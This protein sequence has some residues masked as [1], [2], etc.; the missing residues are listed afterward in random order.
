MYST[1]APGFR[2][3]THQAGWIAQHYQNPSAPRTST[4]FVSIS[5][6]TELHPPRLHSAVFFLQGSSAQTNKLQAAQFQCLYCSSWKPQIR[7]K[8]QD[9]QHNLR[10]GFTLLQVFRHVQTDEL[11]IDC[12][13]LILRLKQVRLDHLKPQ[14]CWE[15]QPE[16][17]RSL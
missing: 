7:T 16:A 3:L 14:R 8:E 4:G 13:G 15:P 11:V 6:C 10:L 17:D 2:P 5:R 9:M 1:L 12:P